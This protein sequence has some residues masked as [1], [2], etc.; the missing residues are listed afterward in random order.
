MRKSNSCNIIS[1]SDEHK[2]QLTEYLRKKFP[3][4]S[5]KYIRYC[6][7]NAVT[8]EV[9]VSPLIVINEKNKI[10]GCH[11]FYNTHVKIKGVE[12]L[13]RWGHDT[14]LDEEYRNEIGFKFVVRIAQISAFGIGLSEVNRDIQKRLKTLFWEGCYNYC[15]FMPCIFTSYLKNRF[16][17]K[18]K[19]RAPE[20]IQV[21]TD[22]IFSLEKDTKNIDLQD[23]YLCKG[24]DIDFIRDKSFL[25][26]RFMNNDTHKY[27]LYLLRDSHNEQANV[28]YFVLRET[29]FHGIKALFLVDFRYNRKDKKEIELIFKAARKIARTNLMGAIIWLSNDKI[30]EK[31]FSRNPLCIKRQTDFFA[32]GHFK[33]LD[34]CTSIITA[35]DADADF[36]RP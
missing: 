17:R 22:R 26:K 31:K 19:F 2:G 7:N 12:E 6:I 8:D 28:C 29:L 20:T 11:L 3:S 35:A 18:K 24:I 5:E 10:V 13:T 32:K 14:I 15:L 16:G 9:G 33:S 30:V 36:M 21:D 27:L 23:G 25:N 4:Y 34:G 1:F